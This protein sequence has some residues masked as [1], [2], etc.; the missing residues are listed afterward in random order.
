M[1]TITYNPYSVGD[2]TTGVITAVVTISSAEAK[3][4]TTTVGVNV[5]PA[6]AGKKIILIGG[7]VNYDHV[8][9]EYNVASALTFRYSANTTVGTSNYLLAAETNTMSTN[10]AQSQIVNLETQGS[11]APASNNDITGQGVY[12][13]NEGT[14]LTTGDGTFTVTVSYLLV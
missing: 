10:L 3:S 8:T 6:T 9:T 2:S 1:P 7:V 14:Q 13:S 12:V 5:I 11:F 4:L